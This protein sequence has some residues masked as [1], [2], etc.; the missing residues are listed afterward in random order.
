MHCGLKQLSCSR[1]N[2][3]AYGAGAILMFFALALW[4]GCGDIFRPVANPIPGATTDPRN[5]HVA[6]V[7]SQNAAGNPGTAMQ[8]DVSGDSNVGVVNTGQQ[9]IYAAMIAQSNRVFVSN[10]DGTIASFNPAGLFGSIGSPTTISLPAGLVP[11]FL[12]ST[13][14]GTMYAATAG[15]TNPPVCPGSALL[16]ISTG[17]LTIDNV[18]CVGPSPSVLTETPDGRKVYSVNGD[19][20]I[21]SVNTVD[22][23]VNPPISCL[24]CTP[25]LNNPVWAVASVDSS[26]VFVLDASGAIWTINTLTDQVAQP[27]IQ[28][29][30]PSNFMALDAAHNRLYVTSGGGSTPASVSILDASTPALSSLTPAPLPLPAGT[31][32]VMVSFLPNGTRAYVLSQTATNLPVITV[33]NPSNNTVFANINLPS[34]TPNPSAVA[35]CQLARFPFSLAASGNSSRLYV[36][37]CYAA[38]TSIINTTTN[39]RLLTMNSPTSAY[40]PV[41]SA[42]YPPPQNPVFVVAGP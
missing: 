16:A 13:E 7:V 21:S 32:P 18:I 11:G 14:S 40:S 41:G 2:R 35:A 6:V 19:G 42:T 23:S 39:M 22:K 29:A 20:T 24:S 37:D 34:A 30:A 10:S 26:K 36:A 1:M 12:F 27:P 5:Y 33:I 8:I 15:A 4:T 38:S 31:T 25:S 9:P 3:R 17:S 28:A